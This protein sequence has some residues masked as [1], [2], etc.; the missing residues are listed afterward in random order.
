M[1]DLALYY[2]YLRRSAARI[3]PQGSSE[4]QVLFFT[5][6]RSH[7]SLNRAEFIVFPHYCGAT[8]CPSL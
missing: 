2:A 8:S 4:A 7:L 1:T 5:A 3:A 6:L